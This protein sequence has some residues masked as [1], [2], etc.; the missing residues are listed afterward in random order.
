MIKVNLKALERTEKE[1]TNKLDSKVNP[2]YTVH[3]I[4][5]FYL[6]CASVPSNKLS[7]IERNF[8]E[9]QFEDIVNEYED[10]LEQKIYGD[11]K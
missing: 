2:R 8:I 11:H 9:A 3:Q 4:I 7:N 1:F 6:K 10:E 5:A